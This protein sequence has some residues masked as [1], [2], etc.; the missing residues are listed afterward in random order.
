MKTIRFIKKH[1]YRKFNPQK[2]IKFYNYAAESH[3]IY[4]LEEIYFTI[5][6]NFDV[7]EEAKINVNSI[8]HKFYLSKPIVITRN[9]TFTEFLI[10]LTFNLKIE[11]L[12]YKDKIEFTAEIVVE[13]IFK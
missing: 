4:S 3:F 12:E 1:F 11:D 2:K 7:Y 5:I 10:K 6:D 8:Y 9:T 13:Y